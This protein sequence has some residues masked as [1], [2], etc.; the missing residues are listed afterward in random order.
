MNWDRIEGNW[1]HY[2]GNA[3]RHWLRLTEEQL[4][5]I[6][7]RREELSGKIQAAYG[8]STEQAEKQVSSWQEAQKTVMHL[9]REG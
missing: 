2:K 6:A 7:G 3:K 9:P 1:Q 8:I 4:D 5:F